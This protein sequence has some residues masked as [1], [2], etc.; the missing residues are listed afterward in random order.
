[1]TVETTEQTVETT[2]R[3]SWPR[4]VPRIVGAAAEALIGAR[5]DSRKLKAVFDSSTSP[6]F[7]VDGGR[8]IVDVNPPAR[9][10]FRISAEEMCR[11]T[12]DDLAPA[13]QLRL[14]E[15]EW[16]RMLDTGCVASHYMAARADGSRVDVVCFALARVVMGLHVFTFAPAEWPA[17]ELATVEDSGARPMVLL[18]P[19]EIEVLAFAA[20]G[21]SE[22]ELAEEL[23]LSPATIKTHFKN[24]HKK[25]GVRNRAAAVARA[26]R[27]GVID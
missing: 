12:M 23:L 16:A 10:W 20:D 21:L 3:R 25:L 17:D 8:R 24:I 4:Q 6:M 22:R 13:D 9:L 15:L 7:M 1:M 11:Y 14:I 19:R 2:E 18:T 5:G 27:L 26:M